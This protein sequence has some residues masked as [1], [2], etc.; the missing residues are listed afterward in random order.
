MSDVYPNGFYPASATVPPKWEAGTAFTFVQYN[1]LVYVK[2]NR[3]TG[4]TGKPNEEVD[5]NGIRTWG[6]Y[7]SSFQ[8]GSA[9]SN[10]YGFRQFIMPLHSVIGYN[11]TAII[12][13]ED[14]YNW[15]GNYFVQGTFYPPASYNPYPVSPMTSADCI[16]VQHPYL[17]ASPSSAGGI[18]TVWQQLYTPTNYLYTV[19]GGN[20]YSSDP[21][22]T[23]PPSTPPT[24]SP[25]DLVI[26]NYIYCPFPLFVGRTYTGFIEKLEATGSW[27]S[28]G[29]GGYDYVVTAPTVTP[30]SIS[31][32][33]T[34]T[35]Y[36]EYIE[37]TSPSPLPTVTYSIT[38]GE[39]Y[40]V[41]WG[42]IVLT[43]V[44]P[45]ATS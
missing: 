11:S 1:G 18:F 24:L 14:C 45:D 44:S 28:N 15:V 20:G 39:D 4:G 13:D 29:S 35:N 10:A 5:G 12:Y 40:W 3:H 17:E 25:V 42:Q 43:S 38:G 30:V 8:G 34:Q 36:I 27:V 21:P 22:G 41:G 33:V 19:Y 23:S 7:S 6:L 32:T 2:T 31:Y 16:A 37:G 9:S 26:N